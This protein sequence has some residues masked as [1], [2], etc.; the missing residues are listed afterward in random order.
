VS[1]LV[2]AFAPDYVTAR[3]RFRA[4]AGALDCRTEVHPMAG[5][6][7]HGEELTIDVALLGHESAGRVVVLSSGLHGA[8]GFFGSAVQIACLEGPLRAWRPAPGTAVLLLHGLNPFGFAYCRRADENNVDLNRNF[9]LPG[10]EYRGSPPLLGVLRATFDPLRPPR[11]FDAFWLRAMWLV[12]RHGM[13]TL[14]ETLPH[15]QYDYP[16]WLFFGGRGPAATHRLLEE[17]MPRWLEG[18]EAAT[19]LDF[20]TGLG[21]WATYKLLLDESPGWWVEHYGRDVVE[22]MESHTT[23]YRTRGDWGQ[24]C[25]AMF[26]ERRY[27][28]AT[29]EFGTHP[30][31]HV[32]RALVNENRAYQAGKFDPR[33]DWTRRDMVEAFAPASPAWRAAVLRQAVALVER[34][35][36]VTCG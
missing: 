33:Y 24:W 26:P 25:Q 12:I 18:A 29:A 28:F 36:A 34:T 9:L 4:A 20:H 35:L 22:G 2:S 23:G 13:A 32:V 5:R 17:Q 7:P 15:G 31:L 10:E 27:H 21:A 3:E 8:E 30:V 14:R 19:H 11:R 6:G 1:L 16:D